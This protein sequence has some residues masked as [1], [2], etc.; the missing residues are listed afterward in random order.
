[1]ICTRR[2]RQGRTR[3]RGRRSPRRQRAPL[4][5]DPSGS[6]SD[7][8]RKLRD[9]LSPEC[10]TSG[11]GDGIAGTLPGACGGVLR[12]TQVRSHSQKFF[13]KLETF[14]GRGLPTMLR[15]RKNGEAK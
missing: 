9:G 8:S 12:S 14:R 13:K 10:R 1:M 7:L 4:G 3:E 6:V 2:E 5:G 15:K 11:N